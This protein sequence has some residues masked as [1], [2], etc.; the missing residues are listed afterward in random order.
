MKGNFQKDIDDQYI[1][2]SYV[3]SSLK[4]C[5]FL[6]LPSEIQFSISYF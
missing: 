5:M 2:K 4:L 6:L 1:P 3:W